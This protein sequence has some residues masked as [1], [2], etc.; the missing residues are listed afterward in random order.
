MKTLSSLAIGLMLS[1]ILLATAHAAPVC[2]PENQQGEQVATKKPSAAKVWL[3]QEAK[4]REIKKNAAAMRQ[5]LLLKDLEQKG[6][7]VEQ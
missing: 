3:D 4:R 1:I 6:Q 7:Q 5:Q 2:P